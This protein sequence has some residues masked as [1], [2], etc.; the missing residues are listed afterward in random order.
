[1]PRKNG[2]EAV[3][4]IKRMSPAVK[5][6]FMSGYTADIISQR[7]LLQEDFHFISK[8]LNPSDLLKTMRDVL[9][10]DH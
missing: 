6:L 1:M 8:P 2:R 9:R 7:G 10:A 5:V 3:E 4:E